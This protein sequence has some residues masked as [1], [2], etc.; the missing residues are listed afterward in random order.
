VRVRVGVLIILSIILVSVSA[1]AEV[2]PKG[3]AFRVAIV[4]DTGI[5]ER[6]YRPGFLAVQKALR[7]SAPD[8][9]LHLGDFVYQPELFPSACNPKYIR[10]VKE[11]LVDPF[12][13]R[14]F[15]GNPRLRVAGRG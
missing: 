10:E 11:T 13:A 8:L 3:K 5:G 12:P 1:Q 4:G 15:V 7:E 9:L 14:L 2:T 6:A